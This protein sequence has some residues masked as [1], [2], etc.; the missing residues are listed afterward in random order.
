MRTQYRKLLFIVASIATCGCANE[1]RPR[2]LGLCANPAPLTGEPAPGVS[3]YIVGFHEGVDT[4]T[5]TSRLEAQCGFEA[6]VVFTSVPAFVAKL[7]P[8]AL[9]C[10][11]CDP[12]VRSVAPNRPSFFGRGMSERDYVPA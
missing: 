12:A 6:S 10:V 4:E 11:R 9:E 8:E 1:S 7:S 5:E 3:E 2:L